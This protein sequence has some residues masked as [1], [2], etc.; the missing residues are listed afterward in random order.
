M[1]RAGDFR[2]WVER[3]WVENCEERMCWGES[4]MSQSDFFQTYKWILR[5]EF[6]HAQTVEAA[7]PVLRAV[8]NPGE[9]PR[10]EA[11]Y[12]EGEPDERAPEWE[13]VEWTRHNTENGARSGRRVESWLESDPGAEQKA[14]NLADA[15]QQE[16]LQTTS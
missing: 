4:R 2:I 1:I 12:R 10:F 15:L 13:V 16:Y 3:F 6:R 9:L 14:K 8:C 11:V 7:Q 5:R